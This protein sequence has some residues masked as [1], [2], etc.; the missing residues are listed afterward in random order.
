MVRFWLLVEN[1]KIR[2]SLIK[3]KQKNRPLLR[4]LALRRT[5]VMPYVSNNAVRSI[6]ANDRTLSRSFLLRPSTRVIPR[7]SSVDTISFRS[8]P[9]LQHYINRHTYTT[10]NNK[11]PLVNS[12][13]RKSHRNAPELWILKNNKNKRKNSR[14]FSR[15]M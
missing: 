9:P 15:N 3:N 12:G 13:S 1:N 10:D 5:Y 7:S 6:N 14:P 4:P 2:A 8:F 11:L